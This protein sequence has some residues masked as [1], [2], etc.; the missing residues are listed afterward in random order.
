MFYQNI[1]FEE[2]E[3]LR[4]IFSSVVIVSLFTQEVISIYIGKPEISVGK[5]NGSGHS[6]WEASE[7]AYMGF[8]LRR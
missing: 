3:I 4:R 8:S 2:G 6:V 5:S 7:N 1:C